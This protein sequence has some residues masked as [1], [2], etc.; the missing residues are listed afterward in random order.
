MTLKTFNRRRTAFTI[1]FLFHF[2]AFSGAALFGEEKPVRGNVVVLPVPQPAL[3][4]NA[5]LGNAQKKI[6]D[7]FDRLGRFL[8]VE[9]NRVDAKMSEYGEIKRVSDLEKVAAQ[10]DVSLYVLLSSYARGRVYYVDMKIVPLE[11]NY[12]FL[13]KNLVIK[14][15]DLSLLPVKCALEIAKIHRNLSLRI[16]V[17]SCS[18]SYCTVSAGQWHGL[19]KKEYLT[20]EGPSLNV[21]RL[22]RYRAL[23]KK[24]KDINAGSFL[25]LRRKPKAEQMMKELKRER[26]EKILARYG[27]DNTLLK[28]KKP[29]Q[30][31]ILG[32]CIINPGA[33]ACLPGYG[34]WL[35]TGYLNLKGKPHV[36]GVVAAS[37]LT[38]LHFTLTEM[39][40]GFHSNFFP[41]VQDGDKSDGMQYLHIFLWSSVPL[42]LTNAWL[43][44]LA[45][46]YHGLESFPPFFRERDGAAVAFSLFVP[47]AGLIYKGYS[48][49]GWSYYAVEM[50]L[51]SLAAWYGGRGGKTWVY[52]LA[53]LSAVKVIELVHAWL[54]EPAYSLYRFEKEEPRNRAVFSFML[55]PSMTGD[56]VLG[57]GAIMRF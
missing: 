55:R 3:Q 8:P 54:A 24:G 49:I 31:M 1:F 2:F 16:K 50:S 45:H 23:V 47:G 36:P 53:G 20:V 52:L 12:S 28:G 51:A 56:A 30:K 35:A 14:S 39:L 27:A 21:T 57:G 37:T 29:E 34:A 40:T 42:T 7:C 44:Q 5:M 25:T 43:H 38:V 48:A 13:R 15:H 33:N 46:Q 41:W 17:E 32:A 22:Y 26:E 11:K 18:N 6:N 10:L 19:E 9:L 4:V